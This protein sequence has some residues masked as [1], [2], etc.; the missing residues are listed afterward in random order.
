MSSGC[1]GFKKCLTGL[2]VDGEERAVIYRMLKADYH[3]KLYSGGCIPFSQLL[4]LSKFETFQLLSKSIFCKR[5]FVSM[6][7][8]W[9]W[10][11]VCSDVRFV[12]E[13]LWITQ[14]GL[15]VNDIS[16]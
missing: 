6:K 9:R 3:N 16:R 15:S 2:L 13:P 8:E 12:Q 10:D 5:K 4:T 1:E 14:L 11:G 7:T